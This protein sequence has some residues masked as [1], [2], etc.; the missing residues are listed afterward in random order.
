MRYDYDYDNGYG[1]DYEYGD[2]YW[3][4]YDHD[5]VMVIRMITVMCMLMVCVWLWL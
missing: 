4:A 1:C 5:Y 3:C 2:G